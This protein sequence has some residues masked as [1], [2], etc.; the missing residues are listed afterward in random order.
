MKNTIVCVAIDEF[1]AASKR[2]EEK[3]FIDENH[4]ALNRCCEAL[5]A[6]VS[7]VMADCDATV[8]NSVNHTDVTFADVDL[9]SRPE[10]T[11]EPERREQKRKAAAL[12]SQVSSLPFTK[13][14][15]RLYRAM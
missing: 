14:D 4:A 11:F 15:A 1:R 10:S 8:C 12:S 6:A 13:H 3:S 2:L 7:R 5:V 9:H